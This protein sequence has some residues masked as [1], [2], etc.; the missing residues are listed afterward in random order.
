ML[1]IIIKSGISLLLFSLEKYMK[2]KKDKDINTPILYTFIGISVLSFFFF[3]FSLKMDISAS[4]GFSLLN[5]LE[6]LI[7]YGIYHLIYKTF[8]RN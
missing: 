5:F 3:M 7:P 4:F 1:S 8:S 2:V 6:Y